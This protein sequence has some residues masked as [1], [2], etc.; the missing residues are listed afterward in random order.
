MIIVQSILVTHP[1]AG[2]MRLSGRGKFYL[3]EIVVY[4]NGIADHQIR[5]SFSYS[6][7]VEI[8]SKRRLF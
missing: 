4:N 5:R 2:Y 7:G 6:L 3:A 8:V 1:A